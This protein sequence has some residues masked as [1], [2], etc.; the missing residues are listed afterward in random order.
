VFSSATP[1]IAQATQTDQ[2]K[3]LEAFDFQYNAIRAVKLQSHIH[4]RMFSDTFGMPLTDFRN[5]RELVHAIGDVLLCRS[6]GRAVRTC[7]HIISAILDAYRK[8]RLHRDIS[9]GNILLVRKEGHHE[10]S[11]VLIDWEYSCD[12]QD[13]EPQSRM[14]TVS[15]TSPPCLR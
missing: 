11:G 5:G 8:H 4:Y 13:H 2:Q 12:V 14:R 1:P 7:T 10:R 15:C 3:E 9:I 6:T